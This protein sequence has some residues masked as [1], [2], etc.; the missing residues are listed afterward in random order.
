MGGCEEKGGRFF[1]VVVFARQ[2]AHRQGLKHLTVQLILAVIM[3]RV[4]SGQAEIC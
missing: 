4:S 3:R 1:L 2:S